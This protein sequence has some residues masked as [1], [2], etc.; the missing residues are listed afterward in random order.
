MLD[1][2]I[3]S[4]AEDTAQHLRTVE[5]SLLGIIEEEKKPISTNIYFRL[6]KQHITYHVRTMTTGGDTIKYNYMLILMLD[7][8]HKLHDVL[9]CQ[10]VFFAT[11]NRQKKTGK[12]KRK[13]LRQLV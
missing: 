12:L 2:W 10:N 13:R 11:L 5:L 8:L 9:I 3:D 6:R 1:H 7:L 4:A